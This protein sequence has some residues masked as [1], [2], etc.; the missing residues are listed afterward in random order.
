MAK[1]NGVGSKSGDLEHAVAYASRN[2]LAMNEQVR[3][4]GATCCMGGS[5]ILMF[6]ART[7][8]Y[9]VIIGENFALR[10]YRISPQ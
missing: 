10:G 4:D 8:T 2:L 5:E 7:A 3:D 1:I 6:C 9:Y